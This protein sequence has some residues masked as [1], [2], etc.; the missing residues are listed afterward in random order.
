M[1][2]RL[3]DSDPY[4]RKSTA[5]ALGKIGDSRAVE[6]LIQALKDDDENVR[7]SASKALEKITGQKY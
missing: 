6:P 7:S 2:E 5:E 4:V 1:I 3:K